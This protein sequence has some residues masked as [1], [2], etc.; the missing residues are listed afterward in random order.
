MMLNTSDKNEVDFSI[1]TPME[2]LQLVWPLL[3]ASSAD[4]ERRIADAALLRMMKDAWD[5]GVKRPLSRPRATSIRADLDYIEASGD[6][7]RASLDR[8]RARLSSLYKYPAWRHL[9]STVKEHRMCASD[10]DRSFDSAPRQ[11]LAESNR[12]NKLADISAGF[13]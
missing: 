2:L 13:L 11:P 6:P 3:L 10:M 8:G 7:R 12:A 1:D 4:P 5:N 9:P